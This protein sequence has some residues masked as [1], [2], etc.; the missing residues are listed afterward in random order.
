MDKFQSDEIE[1]R[2]DAA[3]V[4]AVSM[5]LRNQRERYLQSK[6]DIDAVNQA[7][8]QNVI[9]LLTS[10]ITMLGILAAMFALN[11]ALALGSVLVV[12]L[13][14]AFSGFIARFTRAGFRRLQGEL[15]ELNAIAEEAISGQR[16]IKAFKRDDA[17]MVLR[18]RDAR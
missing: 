16:V 18:A 3:E 14:Y 6:H 15:G 11:P 5:M 17:A 1:W 9:S 13:M 2:R 4:N 12:P 7:L 10:A 8:S